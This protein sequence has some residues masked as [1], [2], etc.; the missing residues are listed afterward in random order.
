MEKL[1]KENQTYTVDGH[2]TLYKQLR[3]L[4]FRGENEAATIDEEGSVIIEALSTQLAEAQK[5]I[6]Q[7]EKAEKKVVEAPKKAVKEGK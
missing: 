7:L 1:I 4:G 2:S 3:E 5:E 6:K